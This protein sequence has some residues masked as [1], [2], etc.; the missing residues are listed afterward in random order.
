MLR[1][2]IALLPALPLAIGCGDDTATGS[3][4]GGGGQGGG[5]G[6]GAAG[7]GPS[8][9]PVSV[10]GTVV[11]FETGA[12]LTSAATVSV[13]GLNP[14]PTISTTGASFEISGVAPFSAFHILAG[15]PPDYRSTY[16]VLTEV[17]DANVTGVRAA[18]VAETFL[19][20]LESGFGVTPAAGTGVVLARAVDASGQPRAGVP[21][22]TFWING[23]DTAGP[24]MLDANLQAAS[25]STQTSASGWMVFYDVAPGAVQFS[26]SPGSGYTVV[27][28]SSPV[29][30]TTVTLAELVVNDGELVVPTNVSFSN[31]VVPIFTSRG[32]V[33]C[34]SGA[35]IGADLGG[36]ALNGGD[37][38]VYSE[39]VSEVSP[40]HATTRVDLA[41][42]VNS[43]VLRMPSFE[44]PPDAHPNVTFASS[45]DPDYLLLLGWITEGAQQN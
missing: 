38:K 11:D 26:A 28:A 4:S 6:T 14:S 7:G 27:G 15:S 17:A 30:A 12:D 34:H 18:V 31:D 33:A 42:P 13:T 41:N 23:A 37:N 35:S 40:N 21:A 45:A 9:V 20:G 32:C 29:A 19:D 1:T 36:L 8:N 2:F 25:G 5:T 43:L 24:Y 22:N 44:S 39:L 3:G 16:N 10:S